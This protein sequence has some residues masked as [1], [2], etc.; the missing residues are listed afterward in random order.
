MECKALQRWCSPLTILIVTDLSEAP[1]RTLEVI[2]QA[3][4]TEAKI[5]LVHVIRADL[6]GSPGRSHSFLVPRFSQGGAQTSFDDMEHALLWADLLSNVV[7]LKSTPVEQIPALAESLKVDRVVLT[8]PGS[9]VAHPRAGLSVEQHLMTS[10]T[11]PLCAMSRQMGTGMWNDRSI[12]KVLLPL[13][14]QSDIGL[15]LR[16]ACHLALSHQARL[17]VLH[18]FGNRGTNERWSERT[19]V[20]VEARLPI[21]DLRQEGILC[22]MDVAVCEGEPAKAILKFDATRQHDLI[23]MGGPGRVTLPQNYRNGVVHNV[24]AEA[25]CPVI[26]LGRSLDSLARLSSAF[27][28]D[29]SSLKRLRA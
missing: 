10:L 3:Q 23:V 27:R 17:T 18:A 29:E 4:A 20:A 25:R 12:R 7:V 16:F 26:V 11:M 15:H 13:S 24:I 28:T 19:P 2:R 8:T 5:L 22:P 1:A 21:S 9:S 6:R 14:L